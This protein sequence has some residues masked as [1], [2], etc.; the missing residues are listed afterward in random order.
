MWKQDSRLYMEMCN[1]WA[2]GMNCTKN[3]GWCGSDG[4]GI[5]NVGRLSRKFSSQSSING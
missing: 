5:N 1:E 4:R 2:S 3:N